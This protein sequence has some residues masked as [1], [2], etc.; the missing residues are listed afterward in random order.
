[1]RQLAAALGLTESAVYRHFRSK[2][3]ILEEILDYVEREVTKPLPF[4]AEAR[5]CEGV[6]VFKTLL[7]GLA[8]AFASTPAL[9]RIARLLYAEAPRNEKV[10]RYLKTAFEEKADALTEAMVARCAE[11]GLLECGDLSGLARVFNSFRYQWCYQIA[12]LDRD[13]TLDPEKLKRD[14]Q[15]AIGFFETLCSEP[16]A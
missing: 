9:V 14:L 3:A 7:E 10:R 5:E 6:S 15:P 11:R 8:E 12:I 1:M 13:L 4:E 16:R 2:E